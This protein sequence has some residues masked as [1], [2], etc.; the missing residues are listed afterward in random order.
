M[1]DED[2]LFTMITDPQKRI[3]FLK[4]ARDDLKDDLADV[5]AELSRA[6]I[7]TALFKA[8]DLV[9]ARVLGVHWN[10]PMEWRAAKVIVVR[11]FNGGTSVSY[12]VKVKIKGKKDEYAIRSKIL[13]AKDVRAAE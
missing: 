8:G 11:A 10:A 9:E 2:K 1:T 3:R 6:V 4:K 12:S 13:S 5:E 7:R